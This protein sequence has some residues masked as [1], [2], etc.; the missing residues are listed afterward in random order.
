MHDRMKKMKAVW[1]P[2][3]AAALVSAGCS[4]KDGESLEEL[5]VSAESETEEEG[6]VPQEE[7]EPAETV[8]VYV[9]GAVNAPGV[10][11]LKKDARVFEAITLAGGMTAEA[12]PE[13][14]SQAR[15]VADGEQ[16]YVP[17]V[18]EVQMQGSGVEDIVTGNAD[19]S[20]KVNINTAGK[21]ELMTLTGIGEAKA[22]S[23]LDYREEHGKF[24]SIEDLMLIE[25]IKE[26]VFNK[27][28]EDITI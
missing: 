7:Q 15:T 5:S 11:E 26:G 13:A 24:G 28:K 1:L 12:A 4:D 21:E 18:R 6:A 19:V 14:V 9:C 23:I 2:I 3:L 17:T 10:Y 22:Q 16:I 20:G 27:I 25:G 8:Y